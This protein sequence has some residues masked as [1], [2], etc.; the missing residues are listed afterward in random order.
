MITAASMAVPQRPTVRE[1]LV[2]RLARVPGYLPERVLA[3]AADAGGTL[4]YRTAPARAAR[5]RRNL[6]R[7]AEGLVASGTGSAAAQRAGS[8]PDALERLVRLA[9]RHAARYYGEVARAGHVT[10]GE[11]ERRL[12]L[13]DPETV[14]AAFDGRPMIIVG[15]HFG[16]LELPA[17]YVAQ[18]AGHPVSAPMETIDN[19]ALQQWFEETRGRLGV[20][21]VRIADARRSLLG[22]LRAGESVGLIADRDITGGGILVPFFGHP[23]RLPVGPALL[24]VETDIPVHV[25]GVR[26]SRDGRYRARMLRVEL[27]GEGTRRA[28]VTELTGRIAAAMELI[29]ADA[30][31]QWWGAF[32]P[33]WPDIEDWLAQGNRS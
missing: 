4:W 31:E 11:V 25:A 26:R 1:A 30:P 18:R 9:F 14:D 2:G 16:A 32:H 23:A 10:P 13:D 22:A 7:V 27:P 5:A 6:S 28:R 17:V 3:A 12:I 20:R 21:I 15:L 24:A 8:D 29:I 33:M 19:P